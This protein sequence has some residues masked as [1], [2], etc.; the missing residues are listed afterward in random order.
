MIISWVASSKNDSEGLGWT[1][2]SS[3]KK[4]NKARHCYLTPIILA[5]WESEIRRIVF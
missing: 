2:E 3:I 1:S 5:T 4:K